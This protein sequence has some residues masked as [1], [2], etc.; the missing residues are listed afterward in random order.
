MPSLSVIM[1]VFNGAMYIQASIKNILSQS[2]AEFIFVIVDDGSTDNTVELIKSIEDHRIE[3][4]QCEHAGRTPSLNFALSKVQTTLVAIMDADDLCVPWRFEKQVTALSRL[5]S[6]TLLS[7]WYGVFAEDK[8]MHCVRPRLTSE[9][10]AKGLLLHSYLPHSGLMFYREMLEREGG[11]YNNAGIDAFEDYQTWLKIKMKTRFVILPEILVY[12]RYRRDSLTNNVA[13]KQQIMYS[14]Q[15][16]YYGDLNLAFGISNRAEQLLYRGWREYFY[17][18]KSMA[19]V[20]WSQL[21]GAIFY[22]PRVL[23]AMIMT[24]LPEHL[25]IDF[26]E[27]RVRYRAGYLLQYYSSELRKARE[28]LKRLIVQN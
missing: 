5:P 12:Q 11:Y 2:F 9:E 3:L 4:W 8:L 13:Y 16:P 28:A 15:Q 1:T 26:K 10:I 14:I 19:R 24:F 18:E 7:S 23:L 25:F 20:Y 17:G 21:G 6:N 27:T 22:Q